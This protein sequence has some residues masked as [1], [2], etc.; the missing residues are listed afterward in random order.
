MKIRRKALA[1][2]LALTLG[3]STFAAAPA[4]AQTLENLSH[5]SAEGSADLYR[6]G[7]EN[8]LTQGSVVFAAV[9]SGGLWLLGCMLQNTL[10][11]GTA[12]CTF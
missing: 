2:A 11:P 5:Q 7:L 10:A 12:A 3:M 9:G 8:P 1:S 6:S 4:S